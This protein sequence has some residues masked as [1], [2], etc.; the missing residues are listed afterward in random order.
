MDGELKGS[1]LAILMLKRGN[2][3]IWCAVSDDSDE[4][5]MTD[6]DGNDFTAY[7]VAFEDGYFYCTAGMQWLY[8]VPIR[9]HE[10]VHQEAMC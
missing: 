6:H 4:E 7:I 10:I 1:D 3:K 5:A 8:A 9:I 2:K